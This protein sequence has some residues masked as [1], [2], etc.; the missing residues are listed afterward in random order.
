MLSFYVGATRVYTTGVYD[1]AGSVH[2]YPTVNIYTVLPVDAGVAVEFYAYSA[3]ASMT[4]Y[5]DSGLQNQ[6]A[7]FG[8]FKLNGV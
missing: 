2:G 3:T 5:G 6:P 1:Q 7:S 4:V 8:G